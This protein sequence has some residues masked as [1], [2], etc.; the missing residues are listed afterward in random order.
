MSDT[1]K[2]DITQIYIELCI[3][4]QKHYDWAADINCYILDKK[5]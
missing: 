5:E 3:A 2:K 4:A 1:Q